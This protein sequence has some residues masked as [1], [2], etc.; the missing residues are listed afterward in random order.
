MDKCKHL[1]D[2]EEGK[3]LLNIQ[4][5]IIAEDIFIII[6][7]HPKRTLEMWVPDTPLRTESLQRNESVIKQRRIYIDPL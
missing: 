2:I 1:L 3:S 6:N 5:L 4:A 7:I